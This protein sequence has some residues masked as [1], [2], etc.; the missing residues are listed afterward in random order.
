[1]CFGASATTCLRRRLVATSTTKATRG[2]GRTP[3]VTPG[4]P[5]TA[6]STA[7]STPTFLPPTTT[8]SALGISTS[9]PPSFPTDPPVT[10]SVIYNNVSTTSP[11]PVAIIGDGG[12]SFPLAAVI[13]ACV[14][15]VL[16]LLCALLSVFFIRRR[17]WVAKKFSRKS[18]RVF[19]GHRLPRRFYHRWSN[20]YNYYPD[21]LSD[22]GWESI[23]THH[24]GVLSDMSVV[25]APSPGGYVREGY[26][27]R[28][29]S[30]AYTL[31]SPADLDALYANVNHKGGIIRR[32]TTKGSSHNFTTVGHALGSGMAGTSGLGGS[33]SNIGLQ[34]DLNKSLTSIHHTGLSASKEYMTLA[35]HMNILED[36]GSTRSATRTRPEVA[37]VTNDVDLNFT[38]NRA[39]TKN[40]TGSEHSSERTIEEIELPVGT[41]VEIPT[42]SDTVHF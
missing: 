33:G 30:R 4:S 36:V 32:S 16:M 17:Q 9:L 10:N 12:S 39:V 21:H 42:H 13:A 26:E 20:N 23:S 8:T 40:R 19:G 37:L 3:A 25:S 41:T 2:G 29:L 34:H 27:N 18:D 14:A 6:S 15:A 22:G 31:A 11:Q 38:V 28:G 1:M 5:F 35:A 24:T 7:S